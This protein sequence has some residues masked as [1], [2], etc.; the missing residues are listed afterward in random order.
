MKWVFA[1]GVGTIA[2]FAHTRPVPTTRQQNQFLLARFVM[3]GCSEEI[4]IVVVM[5]RLERQFVCPQF[6]GQPARRLDAQSM[7]LR[8]R[9]VTALRTW[10]NN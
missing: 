6:W 8:P 3:A 7:L 1:H 10:A 9:M 5:I 2:G 4:F